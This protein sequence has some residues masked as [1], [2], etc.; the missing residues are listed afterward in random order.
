MIRVERN[1][2]K[3]FQLV[4]NVSPEDSVSAEEVRARLKV[5]SMKDDD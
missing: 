4:C 1:D 3:M 2:A 5:N